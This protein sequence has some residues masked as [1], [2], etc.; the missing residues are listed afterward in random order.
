MLPKPQFIENIFHGTENSLI[1]GFTQL[2][3]LLPIIYLNRKFFIVGFKR[4]LKGT[5]NMDSLIAM[6]SS[7]A[8]AYGIFAIYMIGH[9]LGHNNLDTVARYSNDLYFES[10]GM[11]LTLVT[12]GKYLETKS[13]GKTKDAISKLI[14]LAPK[15]SIVVRNGEEAEIC[16]EEIIK[17]DIIVIKPGMSIPVDGIVIEGRSAIDQSSITGES[18]PVEKTAGDTV[19][20]GTINKNGYFKMQKQFSYLS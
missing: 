4:I 12:I 19:V 5:P 18:M 10:A 2:L 14:N 6:G 13:K 11:I 15:T 17:G 9:G 3:L 1:Y 16:T 8:I 20:S 7:A